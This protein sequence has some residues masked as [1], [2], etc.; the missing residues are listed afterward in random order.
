RLRA[1]DQPEPELRGLLARCRIVRD[2]AI[3]SSL[4]STERADR[5]SFGAQH[6]TGCRDQERNERLGRRLVGRPG[7]TRM[8]TCVESGSP[9]NPPSD[10]RMSPRSSSAVTFARPAM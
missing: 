10:S 9:G 2:D 4:L 1:L 6:A 8:R 7:G 5:K 3:L